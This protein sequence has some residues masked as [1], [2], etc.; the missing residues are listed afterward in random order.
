MLI[1]AGTQTQLIQH[2]HGARGPHPLGASLELAA[3]GSE[4]SCQAA[5]SLHTKHLALQANDKLYSCFGSV[6]GAETSPAPH[7]LRGE[8]HSD[9]APSVVA[10]AQGTNEVVHTVA[11]HV[12]DAKST[13]DLV[14]SLG[15]RGGTQTLASEQAAAGSSELSAEGLSGRSV[16]G[17]SS[18]TGA[19]GT[20]ALPGQ[21]KEDVRAWEHHSYAMAAMMTGQ[22][23]LGAHG[24]LKS[25][26]TLAQKGQ[27]L[28]QNLRGRA[29]AE[30]PQGAGSAAARGAGLA[31][32][33]EA[34]STVQRDAN[35][36]SKVATALDEVPVL[37]VAGGTL[38]SGI[39]LYQGISKHNTE[40]IAIGATQAVATGMLFTPA[41]PAGAVILAGTAVWQ[42]RGALEHLGAK[43]EHASVA[44]AKDAGHAAV[45]LG[46][47]AGH[48]VSAG[49]RGL[50]HAAA[51]GLS[52]AK[53]LGGEALHDATS[54]VSGWF[55]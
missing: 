1:G 4:A 43:A 49:A 29:P 51:A 2:A 14:K 35:A 8:Q 12:E 38:S 40:Q 41:A 23:A 11:A 20:A 45:T 7:A 24:A 5:P 32:E 30:A 48:V 50:G 54:L 6:A 53:H 22:T 31:G 42:S 9:Q 39:N 17:L 33:A 34:A 10:D 27:G 26:Q 44:L 13:V 21:I 18:A 19:L 3:H 15:G 16:S 25:T 46:K 55:S 52:E 47:D 28:V 37:D 36:L